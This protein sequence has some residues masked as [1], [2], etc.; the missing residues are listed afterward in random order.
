MMQADR[1]INDPDLAVITAVDGL[2]AVNKWRIFGI[3][4]DVR[5]QL[6]AIEFL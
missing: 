5:L 1:I 4:C 2:E 3:D 6:V